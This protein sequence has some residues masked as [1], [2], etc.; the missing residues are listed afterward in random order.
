LILFFAMLPSSMFCEYD[1][2]IKISVIPR[3]LATA[4][5]NPHAS[6]LILATESIA[7]SSDLSR[8]CEARDIILPCP[9]NGFANCKTSSLQP[10][11]VSKKRRS[12]KRF[13][14]C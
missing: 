3:L 7:Y 2:T 11:G 5:I 14:R 1:H 10:L 13:W 4:P 6:G 8:V 12:P 9:A